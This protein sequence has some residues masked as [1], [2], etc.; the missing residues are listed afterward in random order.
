MVIA[1]RARWPRPP[2]AAAAAAGARTS[3]CVEK[4][5]KRKSE[6]AAESPKYNSIRYVQL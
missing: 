3:F 2:D 5:K 1:W 6:S 4:V